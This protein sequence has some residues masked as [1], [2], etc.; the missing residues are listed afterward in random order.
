VPRIEDLSEPQRQA[1]LNF[2]CFEYDTA[3]FCAVRKPLSEIKLALVTTAGLLHEEGIRIVML[4]GDSQTTAKA[5]AG[6]AR[7]R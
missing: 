2:P 3:P 5:V 6:K 7:D 1:V 4:T